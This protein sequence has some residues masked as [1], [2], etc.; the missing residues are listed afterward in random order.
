MFFLLT[1]IS[2]FSHGHRVEHLL[3]RMCML[4]D[5]L[6]DYADA[7]RKNPI[8]NNEEVKNNVLHSVEEA[9]QG[10]SGYMDMLEEVIKGKR[11]LESYFQRLVEGRLEY[12]A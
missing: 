6:D 4:S 11:S 10:L 9:H 1:V 12:L 2:C 5:S 7:I 8:L 3:G